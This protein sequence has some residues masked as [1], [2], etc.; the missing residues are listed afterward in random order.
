MLAVVVEEPGQSGSGRAAAWELLARTLRDELG[1]RERLAD[2]VVER[3]CR[4]CGSLAHGKPEVRQALDQGVH[5]SLSR[6]AERVAVVLSGSGPV[7]IDVE[8]VAAVARAPFDDVLLHVVERARGPLDAQGTAVTWARKEA[9][10]KATGHG[11]VVAASDL[12]VSAPDELPALL[13]WEPDGVVPELRMQD[14]DAGPGHVCA[15][16]TF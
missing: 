4:T 14:V 3:A 9:V 2:L 8:S 1:L 5:V 16:A 15:V 11:L 6:T 10:L 12:V 7:G 13:G